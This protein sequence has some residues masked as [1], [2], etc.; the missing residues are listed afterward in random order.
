M[1][2]SSL[3]YYAIST[4]YGSILCLV[5]YFFGGSVEE[6]QILTSLMLL[7]V[8]TGL[9]ASWISRGGLSSR[10]GYDGAIHK[11]VMLCMVSLGHLL[12]VVCGT[13]FIQLTLIYMYIGTEGIS[14]TENASECG[15]PVPKFIVDHLEQLKN[16]GV[17]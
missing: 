16:K 15:V 9:C 12:D 1:E 3:F 13:T 7:D 11:I 5:V 8:V 4:V 6:M 14:I 2:L 10:K 17:K